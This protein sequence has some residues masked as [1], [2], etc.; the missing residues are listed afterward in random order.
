[1]TGIAII[2]GVGM[3][4]R[5]TGGNSA[6]D[7]TTD[8]GTQYLSVIQRYDILVPRCRRYPVTG[9]TQIGGIGVIHRFTRCHAPADVTTHAT[10]DHLAVIQR[11][12]ELQEAGRRYPVTGFT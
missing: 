11:C 8:T 4:T 12:N 6:I 7:V 9:L 10:A 3:T 1:M 2:R 5:L